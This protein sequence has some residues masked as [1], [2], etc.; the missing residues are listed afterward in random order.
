MWFKNLRIYR[1]GKTFE[2]SPEQLAEAL[3]PFVFN[4]V[5]NSIQP[6]T[7]G[8]HHL[9]DKAQSLFMPAAAILWCAPNDRKKFCRPPL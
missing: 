5:E 9:V 7:A 6:V 8:S 4:P 2:S 3:E 1:L